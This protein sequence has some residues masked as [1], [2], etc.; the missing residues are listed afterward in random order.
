MPFDGKETLQ[1]H[2][3][4]AEARISDDSVE[5]TDTEYLARRRKHLVSGDTSSTEVA[6][7]QVP[8]AISVPEHAKEKLA[9]PYPTDAKNQILASSRLL[10]RNLSYS[11]SENDIKE[12]FQ[13]FGPIV[14]VRR[15]FNPGACQ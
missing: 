8:A 2:G 1:M 4:L 6:D 15:P 12:A 11:V 14:E 10:L 9:V 3:G 13:E 7:T 5:M